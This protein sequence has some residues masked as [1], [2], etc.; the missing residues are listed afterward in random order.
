MIH[1]IWD[2]EAPPDFLWDYQTEIMK[3]TQDGDIAKPIDGMSFIIFDFAT[4]RAKIRYKQ[5][6]DVQGAEQAADLERRIIEW[7]IDTPK[8]D[9]RWKYYEIEMEDSPHVWGNM[10]HSYWGLPAPTAY[11]TLRGVR[12]M[13]TRT[14]ETLCRRLA[15]SETDREEQ[16]QYF[17]KTRRILTDEICATVP[18]LLGTATPAFNSPC[19]LITAYATIW[20]LFF[21]GTCA[22]ER[23]G[24]SGY[25]IL[26]N[27]LRPQSHTSNRAAAQA[28]WIMSRLEYISK[29]IGLKW[30]DGVLAILRGDFRI[31]EELIEQ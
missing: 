11:N 9:E 15:F 20:P 13:L 26:K 23:V 29:N 3:Y 12:V 14:Q 5:V 28:Q 25:Y 1:S 18:A 17:R 21:A 31:S 6:G 22:L 4:L 19:I 30:A 10:L 16:M 8:Y 24:S 2:D 27:E 7:C